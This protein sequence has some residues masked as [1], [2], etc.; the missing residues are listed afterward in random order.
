LLAGKT[1]TVNVD[2]AIIDG[3]FRVAKLVATDVIASNGV[4]HVIDKVLLPAP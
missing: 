2:L 4:I 3:N 1:F